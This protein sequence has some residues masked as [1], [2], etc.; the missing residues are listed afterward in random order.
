MKQGIEVRQCEGKF[1]ERE[2]REVDVDLA[3]DEEDGQPG[4]RDDEG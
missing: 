4:W 1:V 2:Q 3:A